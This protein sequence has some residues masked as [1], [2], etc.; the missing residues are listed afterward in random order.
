MRDQTRSTQEKVERQQQQQQHRWT[1]SPPPRRSE[2]EELQPCNQAALAAAY[3]LTLELRPSSPEDLAICKFFSNFVF[4]PRHHEAIRGFLECLPSLFSRAP[5][6]SV[7]P[8]ATSAVSLIVIAGDPRRP[9]ERMLSRKRFGT[10]L[11]MVRKA[12][13]DPIQSIKDETL[14]AVLVS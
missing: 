11:M 1:V 10:A 7:V 6:G 9:H 8:L 14:M 2:D 3:P 5:S 13:E 12:V 4:V